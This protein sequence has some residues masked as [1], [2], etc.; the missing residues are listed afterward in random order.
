VRVDPGVVRPRRRPWWL[1]PLV[2]VVLSSPPPWLVAAAFGAA[3]A[4]TVWI[5]SRGRTIATKA[6]DRARL[7]AGAVRVGTDRAGHP[8]DLSVRQLAAHALIVG[9]SGAGK[10]T[11]MLTIL[12]DHI[13]HGGPVVAI[14]LKGSPA[15]AASLGAAAQA[16]G[17]GI[18]VWSPDG[19][20]HWNPLAH[21][22]ATELKD[23]LMSTERF[24]EPH[25]QRAAERYVQTAIQVLHAVS[26]ERPPTLAGVVAL[27]DSRRMSSALDSAPSPFA[28]RVRDYLGGLTRDQQ[29]AVRGLA[30]RLAVITESHTGAFLEGP[31]EIDVRAAL[32]PGAEVVLFSLNSS[33]YGKLAAQ[34]GTLAVQDL[35][36]AAGERLEAGSGAPAIVAID[37][38]S[39][40]ASDNVLALLARGREAGMSV[41]LATQ[42][43][44]D[45][46]RA[47]RGFRDQ[48]LGNTAVKI[49]HRQDV[50]ASARTVAELIGTHRVTEQTRHV[51]RHPLLGN[52]Y[53]GA[54]R[55]EV[56]RW[57]VDP[58]EIKSL[59]TGQAVLISKIP[60]PTAWRLQVRPPVRQD[61][62]RDARADRRGGGLDRSA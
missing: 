13:G 47:G 60:S 22:N 37:E 29:S 33:R 18:R 32:A 12:G 44:A 10:S 20:S 35:V 50:P 58:N 52:V 7:A 11:T 2:G 61:V 34:L 41:L 31:A 40:L 1:L 25:Y 53:A 16:A 56:E 49:A 43:L 38:F 28:D 46:D 54:T 24:S 6:G 17:R 9:A 30:S 27:L 19:P 26:P 15:F 4:A 14:D 39:A 36:S 5:E 8:I 3:I 23:K 42:E 57:L 51:R 21:G 59:A 55:R 45:L 48:V 62:R